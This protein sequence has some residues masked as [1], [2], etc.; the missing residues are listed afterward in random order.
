MSGTV[1]VN[2][3]TVS[4]SHPEVPFPPVEVVLMIIYE[5]MTSEACVLL[6]V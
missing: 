3:C 2:V 4:D 6:A 5:I 1:C